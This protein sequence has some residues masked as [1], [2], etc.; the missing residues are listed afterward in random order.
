MKDTIIIIVICI[1]SRGGRPRSPDLCSRRIHIL[2]TSVPTRA[3]PIP[4][5]TKT[6]YTP[7]PIYIIIIYKRVTHHNISVDRR[8][9]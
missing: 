3:R 4:N 9:S 2:I 1:S 6:A 5:P 7:I 8:A